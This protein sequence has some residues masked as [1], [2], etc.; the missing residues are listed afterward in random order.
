MTSKEYQKQAAVTDK[1]DY[2]EIQNRMGTEFNSKLIHYVLGIGTEAGELQDAVK[3]HL[4]YG[5]PLDR[6]N[7][8]EE[9]ADIFWYCARLLTLLDS[10]F[11]EAMDRNIAKLR[12]R[13][14]EKF[15]EHA[16]LNRDLKKERKI[17]EGNDV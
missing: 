12:A 1:D 16:A 4:M 7:L 9:A 10:D 15:T 17:L 6:I 2:S 5:K 3:K 11:E 8:I 13:F 14:G